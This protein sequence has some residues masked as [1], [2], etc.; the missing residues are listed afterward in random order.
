VVVA[1]GV[2]VVVGP[3]VGGAIV[4]GGTEVVGIVVVVVVV[5][6]DVVCDVVWVAAPVLVVDGSP[7]G[8]AGSQAVAASAATATRAINRI[9]GWL[10][11]AG[12][13]DPGP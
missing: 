6:V 4:D 12:I 9:R 8:A 7:V 13:R 2:V 10:T 11:V 3:K 1:E 5:V